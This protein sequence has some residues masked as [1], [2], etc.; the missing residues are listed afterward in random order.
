MSLSPSHQAIYDQ[1]LSI[2]SSTT[3]P[4]AERDLAILRDC[5]FE[6]EVSDPCRLQLSRMMCQNGSECDVEAIVCEKVS[7]SSKRPLQLP[8]LS[9]RRPTLALNPS[10]TSFKTLTTVPSLTLPPLLNFEL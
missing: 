3:Q 5:R 7:A 9:V 8:S 6:L 10:L 2:T 4:A 1:L